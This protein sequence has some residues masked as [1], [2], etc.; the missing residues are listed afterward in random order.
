MATLDLNIVSVALPT[1]ERDF[2]I[3]TAVTEWALLA[4]LLPMVALALPSGRWLEGVGTR[5]ALV[6]SLTG[7]AVASVAAGLAPNMGVLIGAR[8]VQGTF[9][10]VLFAL[11]PVLATLAVRRE[12]LGRAMG[13]V[14]TLGPL[15]LVA[16]PGIGGVLVGSVGWPWIFFINV[17]LSVVAIVI[18]LAQLPASGPLRLPDKTWAIETVLLGAAGVALMLGLSLAAST[19]IGWLALTL[20]AVPLV[21][22]W[23]RMSS[24]QVVRDLLRKRAVAGPHCALLAMA[25]AGGFIIFL[26]PFYL[27]RVLGVSE[28]VTGFTILAFPVAMVALGMIGGVLADWWGARRTAL[29]GIVLI[30]AGLLLVIPL[31]EAWTPADLA[32]RLAIVG[33]GTGLFNGPNQAMVMSATPRSLLGD[34]GASTSLTRNLGFAF[35]PVLAT[36][37]WALSNHTTS[38]LR[39]GMVIAAGVSLLGV[40]AVS[41]TRSP[42]RE[43]TP[44]T[45][46]E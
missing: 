37:A 10:A 32:W 7:F 17:P 41:L 12:A 28:S 13:I 25:M 46:P 11:T 26:M 23:C 35:G 14:S 31:G 44:A 9:G 34:V 3:Q 8:A 38:G 29:L 16:G 22:A 2:Q 20:A 27:Q 45:R 39:A 5:A 24:S 33:I 21:I 40:V 42:V 43:L 6:C 19:S 18:V 4:Y 1:I 36:L 15:G 30:T